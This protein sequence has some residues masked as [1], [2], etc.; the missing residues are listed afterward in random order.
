MSGPRLAAIVH[1]NNT[2]RVLGVW[3]PGGGMLK[4]L[5]VVFALQRP[6]GTNAALN[7]T[8]GRGFTWRAPPGKAGSLAYLLIACL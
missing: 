2:R 4:L 1:V 5:A 7:A 3:S 6:L 8:G